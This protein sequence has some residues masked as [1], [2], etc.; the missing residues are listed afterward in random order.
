[1]LL[2]MLL[3]SNFL[4]HPTWQTTPFYYRSFGLSPMPSPTLSIRVYLAE[5]NSN[6]AQDMADLKP[7][8]ALFQDWGADGA[9]RMFQEMDWSDMMSWALGPN[10]A[11]PDAAFQ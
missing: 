6:F 3:G 9:D 10:S 5:L 8:M 1:M 7:D 2:R 11:E 4:S